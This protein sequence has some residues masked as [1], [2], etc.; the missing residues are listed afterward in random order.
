MGNVDVV[1]DWIR[2]PTGCFQL[3]TAKI[4]LQ[5]VTRKLSYRKDDRAMRPTWCRENFWDSLSTPT[6]TFLE[7]LM[8]FCLFKALNGFLCADVQLRNYSL[9]CS[10]RYYECAYK[11]TRSW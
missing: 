4:S 10:D 2:V 11:I 3:P 9:T 6:A 7:L 5:A 1:H 8:G